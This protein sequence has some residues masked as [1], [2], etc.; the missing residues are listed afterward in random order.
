MNSRLFIVGNIV[1]WSLHS[2]SS[3][4][5]MSPGTWK[6][7]NSQLNDNGDFIR[8]YQWQ[9]NGEKSTNTIEKRTV[10]YHQFG[11]NT[12]PDLLDTLPF[13]PPTPYIGSTNFLWN[14]RLLLSYTRVR[15]DPVLPSFI[16]RHK[17]GSMRIVRNF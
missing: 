16:E 7:Y 13:P 11:G 17:F 3:N 10:I 14:D 1:G 4:L 6:A 15:R 8:T 9:M 12:R 5:D 2:L